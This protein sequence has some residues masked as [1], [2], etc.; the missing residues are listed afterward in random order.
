MNMENFITGYPG[1]RVAA[2]D[3][4][5]RRSGREGY[6]R[7]L[8]ALPDG[9]LRRR[10]RRVPRLARA[11]LACGIPSTTGTS[12]TTTAPFELKAGGLPAASTGWSRA[13]RGTAS[14][15]SSTCTRCPA[16][17]TS[18]GTATTR[19][20]GRSSGRTGT[21][22]TGWCTCGRRSRDRYK[23]NAW[24]AGYNPINEPGDASGEVIGPLLPAPARRRS[25]PSIR[26]HILFLDGNRYS[27]DFDVFGDAAGP[28]P[29]TPSHDYAL[30]GFA[31]G[32]RLPG[33]RA[34][35]GTSTAT[36]SRR[37][38]SR[39]P[40]TCAGPARRSGSASS[41][42]CTPAIPSATRCA[43]GCWPTSSRSTA[44]HDA[45]WA[46]WTY[47]DIGLQGVVHAAAGL[48]LPA[49]HRARAR[50]E[51]PAGRRQ[52][53]ARTDAGVRDILDPI[54]ATF[55][56][57]FPG[58]D[59]FPFGQRSWIHVLVRHIL[60]AEPMVD[61]LRALLRGAVHRT[62]SRRWP[63]PSASTAA[64]SGVASPR[65]LR[66]AGDR[67]AWIRVAGSRSR[68]K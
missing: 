51:G 24:V 36:S 38:S 30:P 66:A 32:G 45:S 17:R 13:A 31:D 57:E 63:I 50:E 19:P 14:T 53:G 28:T 43:T 55:A 54:E 9:V 5:A 48:R 64:S 59:P 26:D 49:A 15:R 6:E 67:S 44:E 47:K 12:R 7:V 56:E 8:R 16:A 33:R 2:A 37:P 42:R 39:A 58:F 34:A 27:T 61:G 60:L 23:D 40:S 20:T 52:P 41:V 65:S 11:E 35:G 10:G 21:S 1:H 22:R 68:A 3:G 18:T 29:S 4:A 25:G 46:L 62:R